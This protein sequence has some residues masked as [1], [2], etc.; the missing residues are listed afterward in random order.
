MIHVLCLSY[1]YTYIVG[2]KICKDIYKILHTIGL[3]YKS[4][5]VENRQN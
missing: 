1:M 3:S 5:I 2:Q 4:K